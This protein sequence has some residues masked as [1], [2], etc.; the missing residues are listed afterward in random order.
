MIPRRHLLQ[1]VLWLYA[2]ATT[3][4]LISLWGRA[5]TGDPAVLTDVAQE[6]AASEFVAD[7]MVSAV[8]S[9][10]VDGSGVAVELAQAV[11]ERPEFVAV[12]EVLIGQLVEAATAPPGSDRTVDPAEALGPLVPVVL[13]EAR[14]AG[15]EVEAAMVEEAIAELPV[16]EVRTP[17]N[18]PVAGPEA[19]VTG[20]LTLA[21]AVGAGVMLGSGAVA[22]GLS[23]ERRGMI[24]SLWLRA[25]VS[26]ISFSVILAL[27]AW[28]ADPGGGQ[29]PVRSATA[30]LAAAKIW[31]PMLAA[32][33]T[34]L[35]SLGWR[36]RRR[37]QHWARERIPRVPAGMP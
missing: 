5:L 1:A 31:V 11:T 36:G 37:L 18:L 32:L 8:R 16:I 17:D 6:M 34:G 30:R 25:C 3:V 10:L 29:A 15:L 26:G 20:A 23:S 2:I 33:I 7:R 27:G 9:G 13:D 4:T 12:T 14:T 21:T 35:A 19:P 24:R 28:I 22:V